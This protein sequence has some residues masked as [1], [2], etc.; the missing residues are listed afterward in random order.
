MPIRIEVQSSNTSPSDTLR[1][2]AAALGVNRLTAV[3]IK[4]LY[5]I[6]HDLSED[7]IE[8]LCA[9][10]LVDPV[11]EKATWQPLAAM[12]L[13]APNPDLHSVEVAF[14]PGVTD[15]PARELAR[16]MAEIGVEGGEVIT[17]T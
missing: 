11:T 16:G 2:S 1:Q 4:R 3:T 13:P 6:E 12:T 8:R 5:F 14:R 10:L 9:L 17:G 7:D 15:V